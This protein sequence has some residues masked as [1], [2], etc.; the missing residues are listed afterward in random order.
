MERLEQT[1][2]A[3]VAD[4]PVTGLAAPLPFMYYLRSLRFSYS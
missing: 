2:R 1:Q 4:G 3:K